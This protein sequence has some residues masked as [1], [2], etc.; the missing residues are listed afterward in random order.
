MSL[1]NPSA[2]SGASCCLS[3]KIIRSASVLRRRALAVFAALAAASSV[4]AQPVPEVLYYKF[5]QSGTSVT[6]HATAPPAGTA[7][8][9][10]LGGITQNA[11]MSGTNLQ[12]AVGTG[13]SSSSDYVNTA[14]APN[15][16][17]GSWSIS[18]FTAGAT[19]NTT[20]YYIMGDTNTASFRIF[21]NGVAGSTNWILRGGGTT[22]TLLNGCALS[23]RTMS[24]FVYD[25]STS[26]PQIRSY[27]NGVLN[28]T[29]NQGALG[30]V[31]LT[32]T[33]PFKVIGYSSNV[34]LPA[35][36]Q[37]A[38]VR[39]YSRAITQSEITS[40]FDFGTKPLQ[41]LTFDPAPTVV[42]NG[43]GT[44][45]A[46]SATPN[47]GNAISYA[48]T[49]TDCSV[50]SAGLVT[51]INAG[52]NNCVITATQAGDATY[53]EGTA[54]LTMS[55][56]KAAQTLTLPAQSPANQS[57]VAN[58]TFPINPLATSASPN[59]GTPI[60]YSSLTGSVCSVSGTT[61]TM[62]TSGTCTIAADQAGDANYEAAAQV[63]QSVELLAPVTI[64]GTVAGLAGSGLVLSLNSG[65][66]TLA[67]AADGT[68][69]FPTAI[70]SGASYV[71]TVQT[72][73]SA[74]SQTCSVANG[75]GTTSTSNVTNVAVS[76]ANS[77]FAVDVQLPSGILVAPAGT[78][79]VAAGGTIS[80]T[81]T[82]APGFVLTGASGCGGSLTGNV[83]TT[84]PITAACSIFVT[85][86]AAEV[87]AVPTMTLWLQ[88]L[89]AMVLVGAG[90]R[91]AR[92]RE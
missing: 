5:D 60:V 16:G 87:V 81:L 7:T 52:T 14:W 82:A 49:S 69:T 42:Y 48:T 67:I 91:V 6:N 25:G 39:I 83:Y 3:N 51:G 4:A 12:A 32:G 34:G 55:I 84:G 44:V 28:N 59:A 1:L 40:I 17:T 79:M 53:N 47:S 50:T 23:T 2:A 15:V 11:T 37:V 10:L 33:G 89:L 35:G 58:A 46:T 64:G 78:Q 72:Q 26:P 56:G 38:D 70:A 66:Q 80:F 74:P 90:I 8:A 76:C 9:T 29:V 18:F 27:C 24:T 20:L 86:A 68:F 85:S 71:V 65:A 31:N 21:T 45:N 73:P 61:V 88:L 43:T 63:S 22:D 62:L 36:G 54:T 30:T 57:F 41:T 77:A 19:T 92:L 75:S 13:V